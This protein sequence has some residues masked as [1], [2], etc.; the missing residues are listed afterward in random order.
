V[1]TGVT[2]RG[3]NGGGGKEGG[4]KGTEGKG[5]VEVHFTDQLRV[6]SRYI[7]HFI[8]PT[9]NIQ[10]MHLSVLV[11]SLYFNAYYFDIF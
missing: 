6:L 4:E 10:E 9:N 1:L 11:L 2:E 7:M 3:L 5:R 8:W